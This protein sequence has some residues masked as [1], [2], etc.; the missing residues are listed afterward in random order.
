MVGVNEINRV[1]NE[2]EENEHYFGGENNN[3]DNEDNQNENDDNDDNND[4]NNDVTVKKN[5]SKC[6]IELKENV[7]NPNRLLITTDGTNPTNPNFKD[8]YNINN[9][10][11]GSSKH[12]ENIIFDPNFNNT[13]KF[14]K[15]NTKSLYN[16]LN[17]NLSNN[18]NNNINL[19]N[20]IN[21]NNQYLPSDYNNKQNFN[22]NTNAVIETFQNQLP[23]IIERISTSKI[24]D[25]FIK[26][27]YK[28]IVDSYI[29]Q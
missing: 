26:N 19:N 13:G 3:N 10:N 27:K 23:K 6:A 4:N 28:I 7:K 12:V 29:L 15:N 17:N 8:N 18:N 9:T 25:G 14:N 5:S 1:N 20:N 16:N 2:H 22:T 24:T 21:F 11:T